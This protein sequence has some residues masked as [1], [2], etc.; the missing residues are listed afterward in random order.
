MKELPEKATWGELY[1]PAMEMTDPVKAAEYLNA[2]I[3][4]NMKYFGDTEE[5]ATEVVKQNLGYYAGYYSNDTMI[6]VQELFDCVHPVFGKIEGEA[7]LPT[8]EEAFQSGKDLASKAG[9]E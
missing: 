2:L 5:E 3:Q 6:R 7:D 8:P 1:G 4:R 9:A